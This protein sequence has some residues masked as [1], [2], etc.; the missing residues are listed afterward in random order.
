MDACPQTVSGFGFSPVV[1]VR[2]SAVRIIFSEVPDNSE[3]S[4]SATMLR[5]LTYPK[6]LCAPEKEERKRENDS[7]GLN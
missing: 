3:K 5:G 1:T 2:S 6:I 7:K 4:L